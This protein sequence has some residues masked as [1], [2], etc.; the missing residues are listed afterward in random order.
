MVSAKVRSLL[1]GVS[2]S[3]AGGDSVSP[4]EGFRLRRE[5]PGIPLAL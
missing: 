1:M 4:L 5:T 2:L 3:V